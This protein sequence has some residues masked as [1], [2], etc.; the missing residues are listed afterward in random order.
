MKFN[1]SLKDTHLEVIDELKLKHSDI[2]SEEI[3]KK[4]VEVALKIEDFDLIFG[5]E[6]EKCGGGCFSSEPQFEMELEQ[7]DYGKLK[8]IYDRYDFDKS[9]SEEE[10]ISK[11]IRCTKNLIDDGPDK[12]ST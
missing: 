8:Q 2:S 5:T 12:I 7:E 10:E 4:Y 11:T 9:E 1:L 6:R 3:V